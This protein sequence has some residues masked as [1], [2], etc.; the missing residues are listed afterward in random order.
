MQETTK[1]VL[2]RRLDKDIIDVLDTATTNLGAASQATLSLVMRA[3]VTLGENEVPVEE[4][5]NMYAVVTDAFMGYL[6]QIPEFN[7]S[8]YVEMK[9]LSGPSRRVRRWAGFNWIKHHR[10][11]GKGTASE[12]CYFYHRDAVGSAF[13]TSDGL[14]VEIGRDGEQDYSYAR[15]TSFTGAVVLQQN[16]LV[17]CLHDASGI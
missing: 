4:E 8:Q 3:A 14:D 10:L 17:Q 1:Y 12:K 9:V 7:N 6:M 13:D 16:G 11:T 5:E 15:A 2:N